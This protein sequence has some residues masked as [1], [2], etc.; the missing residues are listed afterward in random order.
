M[1]LYNHQNHWQTVNRP[2]PRREEEPAHDE[3]EPDQ[4]PGPARKSDPEKK[5]KKKSIYEITY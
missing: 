2:A 5:K 3:P 4:Q 1:Y